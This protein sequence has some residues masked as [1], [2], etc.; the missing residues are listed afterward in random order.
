MSLLET[1]SPLTFKS[2][3]KTVKNLALW[4]VVPIDVLHK[5]KDDTLPNGKC[6]WMI[7][8]CYDLLYIRGNFKTVIKMRIDMNTLARPWPLCPSMSADALVL[9]LPYTKIVPHEKT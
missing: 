6:H 4:A 7:C 8:V 5:R 2:L 1:I 3:K 9:K